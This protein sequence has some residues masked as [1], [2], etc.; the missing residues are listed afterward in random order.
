MN[1]SLGSSIAPAKASLL[2]P[3]PLLG[4]GRS[5]AVS[6]PGSDSP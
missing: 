5:T 3:P 2:D 6:E 4:S 1:L